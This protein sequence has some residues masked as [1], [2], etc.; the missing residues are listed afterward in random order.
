MTTAGIL[1]ITLVIVS[2]IGF[3]GALIWGVQ[4]TKKLT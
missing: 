1:F 4:Q 2:M 3:A